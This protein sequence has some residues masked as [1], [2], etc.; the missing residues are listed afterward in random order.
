M[1]K[2]SKCKHGL[3]YLK[4]GLQTQ[5][6]RTYRGPLSYI[7]RFKETAADGAVHLWTSSQDFWSPRIE[8]QIVLWQHKMW[9]IYQGMV[10]WMLQLTSLS[11]CLLELLDYSG[12][13]KKVHF[14]LVCLWL[15]RF[16]FQFGEMVLRLWSP[17][18]CVRHPGA[19]LSDLW[20][21][22]QWETDQVL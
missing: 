16:Y 9:N 21:I 13:N 2:H 18:L 12:V 8:G 3:Q 11:F 1:S 17:R 6:S 15:C 4:D 10:F 14:S 7:T 5:R 20:L 19:W 22:W